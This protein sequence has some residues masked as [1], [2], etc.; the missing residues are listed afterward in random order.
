MPIVDHLPFWIRA[1]AGY[2]LVGD[3]HSTDPNSSFGEFYFGGFG[4]NWIDHQGIKRYREYYPFPGAGITSI[5]A[6]NYVRIMGELILPPLRFRHVGTP[7]FY[8][9]WAR[10]SLFSSVLQGS[11][12]YSYTDDGE[13]MIR[14]KNI[15]VQIDIRLVLFS[16]MQSTLSIGYGIAQGYINEKSNWHD[17]KPE[18]MISLQILD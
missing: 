9:N 2:S 1:S 14:F 16:Y 13:K 6:T 17:F 7:F 18:T 8:L 5:G 3:D 15:G 4:N 12:M 10:M 11:D